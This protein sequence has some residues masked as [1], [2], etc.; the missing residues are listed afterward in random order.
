MNKF[1]LWLY[2]VIFGPTSDSRGVTPMT[3]EAWLEQIRS[4]GL[5]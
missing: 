4:E 3:F 1:I 5:C 2:W